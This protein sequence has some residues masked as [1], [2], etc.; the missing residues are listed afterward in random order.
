MSDAAAQPDRL[1]IA[2][3]PRETA[4]L[5]G[6][7]EAIAAYAAALRSGRPP[8]AWLITGP[9]GTGSIRNRPSSSAGTSMD[10]PSPVCSSTTAAPAGQAAR[11]MV[12]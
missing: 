6:Q 1:P 8:H 11:D 2:P 4:R 5:F 3:H 7:D 10:P 9:R 12:G